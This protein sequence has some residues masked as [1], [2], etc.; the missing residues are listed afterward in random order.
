MDGSRFQISKT[1]K[2]IKG[3]F[4]VGVLPARIVQDF[5]AMVEK[6]EPAV[7]IMIVSVVKLNRRRAGLTRNLFNCQVRGRDVKPIPALSEA[8]PGQQE[9]TTQKNV[10]MAFDHSDSP[11][12]GSRKPVA[13]SNNE[14]GAVL[15]QRRLSTL[16]SAQPCF[17]RPG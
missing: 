6:L 9:K 11:N 7:V 3:D 4:D 15:P 12:R 1:I 14:R 5:D 17:F 16:F 10:A 2:G 8:T 13:L